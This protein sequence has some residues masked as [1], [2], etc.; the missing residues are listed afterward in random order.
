MDITE[1]RIHLRPERK[2]KAFATVT[3]DQTFVVHNVKIV[4]GKKGLIVSMPSRRIKD[5]SFR[6]IAHPITN[7]FRGKLEKAVLDAY[8]KALTEQGSKK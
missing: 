4:E 2:L 3:F 5:G 7:E 6:D 8:N 1:V